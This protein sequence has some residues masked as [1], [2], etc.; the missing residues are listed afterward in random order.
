MEQTVKNK[1]KSMLV[2]LDMEKAFDSVWWIFLYR[3]LGKFDF[4]KKF[5]RTVQTLYEGPTARV[6]IN[7]DLSD[8]TGLSDLSAPLC[9]VY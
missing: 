4:H 2:G 7:G 3:V 6:K 1:T 9:L 5:I 8:E